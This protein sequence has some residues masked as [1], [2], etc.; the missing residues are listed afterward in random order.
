MKLE[1]TFS[2]GDCVAAVEAYTQALAM[3]PKNTTYN[4]TIYCNRAAAKMKIK[5]YISALEVRPF[6]P[7]VLTGRSVD[8]RG[9][10]RS[11]RLFPRY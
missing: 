7:V 8:F 3:D 4:A 11:V 5:G 9:T 1:L 6:I 2:T 10:N